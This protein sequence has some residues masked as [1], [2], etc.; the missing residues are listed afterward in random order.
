MSPLGREKPLCECS[1]AFLGWGLAFDLF[2]LGLV[3]AIDVVV[4]SRAPP[5]VTCGIAVLAT[6]GI[7]WRL[8]RKMRATVTE[9]RNRRTGHKNPPATHL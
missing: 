5:L 7:A 2:S 8:I 6:V 1:T 3:V 9:L 4:F